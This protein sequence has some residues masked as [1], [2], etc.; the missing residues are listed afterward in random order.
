[1]GWPHWQL[2]AVSRQRFK[3]L[4]ASDVRQSWKEE[5][6]PLLITCQRISVHQEK[7]LHA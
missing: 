6:Q 5:L 4:K 7:S 1:M 3:A 2:I